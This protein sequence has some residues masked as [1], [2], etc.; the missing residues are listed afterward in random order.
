MTDFAFTPLA[1]DP[2]ADV[3]SAA[4][5]VDANNKLADNDIGKPVKLAGNDNYVVCAKGDEIAGFVT[6]TEAS[7]VND[8]FSFGSVQR[9]K[10]VQVQ[11]DSAEAGTAV[12]GTLVAAGTSAALGTK[13]VWPQVEIIAA[14]V[15]HLWEVISIIS[16]S[17]LAGDLVLIE[18]I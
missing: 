14:P 1:N 18:K 16:G 9:N 11:V 3:I 7:T 6:S 17:G 15:K 4:L 10:R 13:D 12:V 2:H 5:G 8:G